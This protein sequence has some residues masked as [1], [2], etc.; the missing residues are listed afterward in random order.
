MLF[1][2]VQVSEL[3]SQIDSFEAEME[4]LQVKKGK[5]RPPR[6]VCSPSPVSRLGI[7]W[8]SDFSGSVATDG[9][10]MRTISMLIHEQGFAAGLALILKLLGLSADVLYLV[11]L[12]LPVKIHLEESI[13]RHK[14]H[15]GK[16]EATLRLMD[17][18]EVNPEQVVELKELVEDYVERNQVL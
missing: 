14:K 11:V 17:N 10:L 7:W 8:P 6:L 18:D 16:L 4:G 1:S 3:E 5:T 15:I 13:S 12:F 2:S 9:C